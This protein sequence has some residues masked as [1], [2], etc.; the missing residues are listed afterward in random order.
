MLGERPLSMMRV[1]VRQSRQNEFKSKIKRSP[2]SLFASLWMAACV[3]TCTYRAACG[4][5]RWRAR[6]G[7]RGVACE[8]WRARCGVRVVACDTRGGRLCVACAQPW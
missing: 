4:A 8:V 7:V 5:G 1:R 3:E 2:A 6:C